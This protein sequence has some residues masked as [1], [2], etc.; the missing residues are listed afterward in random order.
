MSPFQWVKI[1]SAIN[2]KQVKERLD[3]LG[4]HVLY[5][6]QFQ[7]GGWKSNN[8]YFIRVSITA[9]NDLVKLEKLLLTIKRT[10]S[11]S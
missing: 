2:I 11:S 8:N 10:I 3:K 5:S 4:I 9:I 7:A 1:D 6:P